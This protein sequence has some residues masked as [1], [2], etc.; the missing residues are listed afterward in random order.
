MLV[1][2]VASFGIDGSVA[3]TVLDSVGLTLNKN[4]IPD[5]PNPPFRPSGIR[6]GTPAITTRGASEDDMALLAGWIV[7]SLTYR[8]DGGRLEA[9][10]AEVKRYASGLIS[11]TE[12]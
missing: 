10:A 9:I 4:S 8:E 3:E 1:D 2:V 5:D 11:P 7:D 12:L 6:L